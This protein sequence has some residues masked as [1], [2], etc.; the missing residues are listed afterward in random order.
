M[1]ALTFTDSSGKYFWYLITLEI[2]SPKPDG[3]LEIFTE[4]RKPKIH[5]IKL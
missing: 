5:E 2:D 1:N 4:I 3:T